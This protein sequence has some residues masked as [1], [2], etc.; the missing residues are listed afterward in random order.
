MKKRWQAFTLIEMALVLF[1]IS[2]LVLLIVPNLASQRSHAKKIN[3]NALQTEL[4]SQAQLYADDNDVDVASVTVDDLKAKGYL[5][6][7]QAKK[8]AADH[9]EI[10]NKNDN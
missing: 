4:N 1:I 7:K 9:L 3:D 2:L 6:N 10:G 5:T 8:I